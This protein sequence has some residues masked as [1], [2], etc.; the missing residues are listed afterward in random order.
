V[1]RK[2]PARKPAQKARAQ[3]R[4]K[5]PR[6]KPAQKARAKSPRKKPAQK[7]RAKA[8]AKKPAQKATQKATPRKCN[9]CSNR[10]AAK[11]KNSASHAALWFAARPI[12][13]DARALCTC[14]RSRCRALKRCWP[15]RAL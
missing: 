6:K 12:S 5:S 15:K 14:A 1:L 2:K 7:A 13:C 10:E 4:A 9:F 3:A 11:N 8:R